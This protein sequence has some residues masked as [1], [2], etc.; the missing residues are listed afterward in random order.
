[1]TYRPTLQAFVADEATFLFYTESAILLIQRKKGA[2]LD[3]S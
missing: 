1:M 2:L 3:G